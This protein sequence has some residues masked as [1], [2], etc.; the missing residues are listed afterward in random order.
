VSRFA[1]IKRLPRLLAQTEEVNK[2][3]LNKDAIH[4]RMASNVR[5]K[6]TR[7]DSLIKHF[8][9]RL[10]LSYMES[11]T[12]PQRLAPVSAACKGNMQPIRKV[13]PVYMEA[14]HA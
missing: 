2:R 14:A 9:N 13:S 5:A 12:N 10:L 8:F 11:G 3:Y 1:T 6:S 7:A 4:S